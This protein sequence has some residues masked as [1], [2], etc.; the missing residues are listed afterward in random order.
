MTG[1]HTP[2]GLLAALAFYLV[3]AFLMSGAW[4]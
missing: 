4:W 3:L 2:W 1:W